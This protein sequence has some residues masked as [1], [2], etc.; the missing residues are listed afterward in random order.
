VGRRLEQ[1]TADS[2]FKSLDDL[3]SRVVEGVVDANGDDGDG[4]GYGFE[5]VV[6][7]RGARAVVA[8]LEDVGVDGAG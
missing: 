7:G 6:A 2:G 4:R 3:V 5:E 1:P 8:D